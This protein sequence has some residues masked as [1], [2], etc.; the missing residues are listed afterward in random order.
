MIQFELDFKNT[1]EFKGKE[2]S[3]V[4]EKFEII[5]SN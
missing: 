1:E 4:D 2:I 5:S 3:I